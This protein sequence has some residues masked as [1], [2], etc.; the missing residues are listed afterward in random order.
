[1]VSKSYSRAA[2]EDEEQ[3]R[4][5]KQITQLHTPEESFADSN[6]SKVATSI[7]APHTMQPVDVPSLQR[8]IGNARCGELIAQRQKEMVLQRV[9]IDN[10]EVDTSGR[11]ATWQQ[12]GTTYHLNVTTDPYHV[13]EEGHA[14]GKKN[15]ITKTHYF[16]TRENDKCKNAVGTG[17]V[18]GSKKK[19]SDLPQVVQNFV[20]KNFMALIS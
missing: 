11:M 2:V 4:K 7:L 13:T 1:M 14:K 3:L 20:E 12:N 5:L 6:L 15:N 10:I 17:G 16:F 9:T 18:S 8:T 19:F